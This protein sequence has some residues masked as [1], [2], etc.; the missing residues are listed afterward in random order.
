[1]NEV[2]DYK[3]FKSLIRWE[4]KYLFGICKLIDE[5]IDVGEVQYIYPK[6]WVNPSKDFQ[7]L[8]ITENSIY[9]GNI[10]S[11]IISLSSYSRSQIR[12]I[13]ISKVTEYHYKLNIYFDD[14][15]SLELSNI[16]D[17]NE[18]WQGSY[19]EYIKDIFKI[20]NRP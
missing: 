14:K 9:I 3:S 4:D 12:T 7:L 10:A 18:N 13:L 20:L 6:N 5:L 11:G 17:S 8:M 19:L 1:M 15:N 16:D 2:N